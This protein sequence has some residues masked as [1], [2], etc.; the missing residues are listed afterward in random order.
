MLSH[1]AASPQ[2]T[3][4]SPNYSPLSSNFH[5]KSK[6]WISA[7]KG[8]GSPLESNHGT[9][10]RGR[11]GLLVAASAETGGA[12]RFYLNFTGFPFPLGPFLNRRTI[13]TEVAI[14]FCIFL[15]K[16]VIF[17]ISRILAPKAV[18]SNAM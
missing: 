8:K 9:K 2:S 16:S 6:S 7:S 10:R 5:H 4:F 17:S 15:T 3:R 12:E 13:R 1:M 11:R 18:T 14:S